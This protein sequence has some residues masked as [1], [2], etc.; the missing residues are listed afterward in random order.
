MRA[1]KVWTPSSTYDPVLW[2]RVL[3]SIVSMAAA[4]MDNQTDRLDRV[5]MPLLRTY[6]SDV[7]ANAARSAQRFLSQLRSD[8]RRVALPSVDLVDVE[9]ERQSEELAKA[10]EGAGINNCSVAILAVGQYLASDRS[11]DLAT[12]LKPWISAEDHSDEMSWFENMF[13]P[14]VGPVVHLALSSAPDEP[15]ELPK[16]AGEVGD[17]WC[18]QFLRAGAQ[19]LRSDQR[20]V[21]ALSYAR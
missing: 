3:A 16:W 6:R 15:K 18:G 20:Q 19:E 17:E 2:W 21:P 5:S 1:G 14:V 9:R 8:Y 11:A 13:G 4:D 7:R 10:L 12:A